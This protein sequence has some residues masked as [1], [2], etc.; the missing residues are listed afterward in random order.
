MKSMEFTRTA[1]QTLPNDENPTV[2]I[3]SAVNENNTSS[4]KSN[5]I[6]KYTV[7]IFGFLVMSTMAYI[8]YPS[9]SSYPIETTG[10]ASYCKTSCS[11]PCS[12]FSVRIPNYFFRSED[13]IEPFNDYSL[14]LDFTVCIRAALLRMD[15]PLWWW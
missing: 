12:I 4:N 7:I 1:Y 5:K 2:F 10:V 11:N 13:T 3:P 9:Q 15:S 8:L 14:I 6:L